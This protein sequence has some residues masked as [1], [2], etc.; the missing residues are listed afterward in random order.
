MRI[1][2]FL[3]DD[4]R[5]KVH[6]IVNTIWNRHFDWIWSC[7]QMKVCC[8]LIVYSTWSTLS[9]DLF[10]CSI[11]S[12]FPTVSV[13]LMHNCSVTFGYAFFFFCSLLISKCVLTGVHICY[14]NGWNYESLDCVSLKYPSKQNSFS[15]EQK[16]FGVLL[17]VVE[18][19]NLFHRNKQNKK[20]N[21]RFRSATSENYW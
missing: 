20:M 13:R 21:N 9:C 14:H 8:S 18:L 7:A 17:A 16:R 6:L 10:F 3:L 4:N 19:F 11:S 1:S 5:L 2:F 12:Q 15:T